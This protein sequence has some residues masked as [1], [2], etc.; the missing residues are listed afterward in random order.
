MTEILRLASPELEVELLPEDGARLHRLRAFGHDAL[1]TP[2]DLELHRREPFFWGSFVMAPWCNRLEAAPTRVAGETVRLP[3]NFAD[4]TAIHGQVYG[5]PWEVVA[6]DVLRVAAG[7]DGWPWAYAVELGI[8]V[9]GPVLHLAVALTNH[10]DSAMPGGIGIH[11]WF[12]QP[13]EIAI[14]AARVYPSNE[15]SSAR[16]DAVD[17]A[18][19]LRRLQPM[20]P[21]LDATW[22]T[23]TGRPVELRWPGLRLGAEVRARP[24]TGYLCAASPAALGAVAI[25]PQT[26]APQGLRRT[27][28]DEPGGLQLLAP[29]DTLRHEIE[30]AFSRFD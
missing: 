20:P 29:G 4:G 17:G 5:R 1:R 14:P 12:R 10:A 27:L 28:N 11:P 19:D 15:A 22:V 13:L 3:A 21:G 6:D 18:L 30:I 8:R 24:S 26:H 25:E 23:P 9:A 16:P 7:G 2:A